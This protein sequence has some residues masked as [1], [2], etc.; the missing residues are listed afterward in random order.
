MFDDGLQD[1]YQELILDHNAR[2]HNFGAL[3]NPTH[4]AHGLNPLCGD[5]IE[6][7]QLA[8]LIKQI[9]GFDGEIRYDSEKP[10]GTPRKLLDSSRLHELGWAASTSLEDGLE[11]T[12]DW[13]LRSVDAAAAHAVKFQ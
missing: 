7:G 6:I 2:P 8:G 10:D 9:T 13:F 12:Y 11:L 5:D 1:L 4:R 3:P